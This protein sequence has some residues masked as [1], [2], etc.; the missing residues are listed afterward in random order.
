MQLCKVHLVGK[1]T[2]LKLYLHKENE[3]FNTK[4]AK[5]ALVPT[6][7]CSMLGLSL[8]L[9]LTHTVAISNSPQPTLPGQPA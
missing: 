8:A 5:T 7:T 3:Y 1:I 6:H 2:D 9:G 4:L